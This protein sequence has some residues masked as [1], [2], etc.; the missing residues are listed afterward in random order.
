MSEFNKLSEFEKQVCFALQSA[1]E[2]NG[3]MGLIVQRTSEMLAPRVAAALNRLRFEICAQ[4]VAQECEVVLEMDR[5]WPAVLVELRV[6]S[7]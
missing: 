4:V 2:A 5:I 6:R 3:A 1:L 7:I